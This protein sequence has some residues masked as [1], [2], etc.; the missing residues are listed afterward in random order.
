MVKIAAIIQARMGSHRLPN[1]SMIDIGGHP[2]LWHVIG[3]TL[4]AI[5]HVIVAT[6][7]KEIAD[8]AKKQGIRVYIGSEDD[9]LD[10]YYQAAVKFGVENIVRITGDSPL[11][12]PK[13]IEEV[14]EYYFDNDFDYVSTWLKPTYP[15]GVHVEI[16]SFKTLE[17]AWKSASD[18]YD[19]EHVTVYIY[20]HPELFRLG[21][22]ENDPD[23]SGMCWGVN[24]FEDLEL[25]RDIY[26]YFSGRQMFGMQDILNNYYA[27]KGVS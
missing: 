21:G 11:L 22:V 5:D 17:L 13:L 2:M 10:R 24:T 19:R 27:L 9:V 14:V 4:A 26:H 12:D 15:N 7:D 3:R 20:H 25:V 18:P 6:P 8:Y 1:K 23:Y 16:F